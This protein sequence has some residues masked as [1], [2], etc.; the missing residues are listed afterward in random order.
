MRYRHQIEATGNPESPTWYVVVQGGEA[1]EYDGTATSYGREVLD[2][3]VHDAPGRGEEMLALTDEYGNATLR[4]LV[5]FGEDDEAFA[6]PAD[7][8]VAVVESSDLAAQT[9]PELAAVDAARE[10]V[11]YAE[12]V[13]RRARAQLGK[14][15]SDARYGGHGANFLAERAAPAASRPV[16]LRMMPSVPVKVVWS[17]VRGESPTARLVEPGIAGV[18]IPD[19][20]LEWAAG[21]GY[22]EDDTDVWIGVTLATAAGEVLGEIAY[23]DGAVSENDGKAIR[24]QLD[25]DNEHR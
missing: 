20:V 16:A 5:A 18:G 22:G 14:A 24:R 12:L 13:G 23:R 6:G 9:D 15:L 3:W 19:V 7:T 21:H 17:V 2:N 4:V 10:A 11:L 1:E 8:A 25:E